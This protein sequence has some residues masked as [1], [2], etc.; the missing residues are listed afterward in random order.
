MSLQ[1]W[2]QLD[3]DLDNRGLRDISVINNGASIDDNGKTGKC[4]SFDGMDDYLEFSPKVD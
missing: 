4:Y 1:V 2:L 3:G